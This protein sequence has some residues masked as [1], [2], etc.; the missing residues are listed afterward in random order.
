MISIAISK[1]L[2]MYSLDLLEILSNGFVW[3]KLTLIKFNFKLSK[4]YF[5][6]F[7]KLINLIFFWYLIFSSEV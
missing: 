6:K 4:L 7:A 2:S 5:F 1:D 3:S